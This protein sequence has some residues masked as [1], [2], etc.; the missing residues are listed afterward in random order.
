VEG[1]GIGDSGVDDMGETVPIIL[2]VAALGLGL[3]VMTWSWSQGRRI[4]EQW[5]QTKGYRIVSS[6][7]RWLRRGPF[8]WTTSKGQMV[9]YVVVDTPDGQTRRGYVRCGSFFWGLLNDKAE[10]RWEE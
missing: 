10:E 2:V 7:V 1:S 9:Y 5:A 8:F 4:L 6:E 3:A